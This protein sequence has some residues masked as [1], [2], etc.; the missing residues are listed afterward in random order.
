MFNNYNEFSK[1]NKDKCLCVGVSR[2]IDKI[3]KK[4]KLKPFIN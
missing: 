1:P 4:I 3:K 2:A